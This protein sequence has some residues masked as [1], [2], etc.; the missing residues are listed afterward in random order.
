MYIY[1]YLY[2]YIYIYICEHIYVHIYIYMY[3]YM[4]THIYIYIYV[5]IYIYMHIYICIYI[6]YFRDCALCWFWLFF[7][8]EPY[9][10]WL[11]CGKWPTTQG[12]LWWKVTRK[13]FVSEIES[14]KTNSEKSA[15]CYFTKYKI[16]MDLTFEKVM[17]LGSSH[18]TEIL[19]SQLAIIFTVPN[20]YRVFF[21]EIHASGVESQN[22][23]RIYVQHICIH[24]CMR[25]RTYSIHIYEYMYIY[26]THTSFSS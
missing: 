18:R 14:P 16:T 13:I 26:Y 7:A 11:I 9:S 20:N 24:M 21:W 4:Y 23:F 12:T 19:K 8:K 15:C 2:L 10:E 5:H 25:H 1:L 22:L 17:C 6:S 3:M